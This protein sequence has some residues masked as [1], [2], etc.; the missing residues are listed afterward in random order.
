MATMAES[1]PAARTGSPSDQ[2][3][4]STAF[5]N[6]AMTSLRTPSIAMV[7]AAARARR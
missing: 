1:S 4:D 6:S 2:T 3:E 7:A 5:S